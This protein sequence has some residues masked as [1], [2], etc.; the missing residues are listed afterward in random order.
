MQVVPNLHIILISEEMLDESFGFESIKVNNFTMRETLVFLFSQSPSAQ[1]DFL[2]HMSLMHSSKQPQIKHIEQLLQKVQGNQQLLD[3]IS[4]VYAYGGVELLQKLKVQH[5]SKF[6]V[7][8][9]KDLSI[10]QAFDITSKI[11]DEHDIVKQL[12]IPDNDKSKT[13][14]Y[15]TRQFGGHY[16]PH[17][18]IS[19]QLRKSTLIRNDFNISP[20]FGLNE[21]FSISMTHQK[22]SGDIAMLKSKSYNEPA[23]GGH[24]NSGRK[25]RRKHKQLNEM[26]DEEDRA[27]L[28]NDLDFEK[29][30]SQVDREE[31]FTNNS[32]TGEFLNPYESSFAWDNTLIKGRVNLGERPNLLTGLSLEEINESNEQQSPEM[33]NGLKS[34][35]AFEDISMRSPRSNA[36]N[37]DVRS[38]FLSQRQQ[39]KTVFNGMTIVATHKNG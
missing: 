13:G 10:M 3:V 30:S 12:H 37:T 19:F 11:E 32:N 21:R 22:S 6:K 23:T 24:L 20:N 18:G 34:K 31:S 36:S 29:E 14:H 38:I 27:S 5:E 7:Q 15:K 33:K 4:K 25:P 2:K 35:G 9:S 17:F 28:R 39:S 26:I 16:N 1:K 8:Q